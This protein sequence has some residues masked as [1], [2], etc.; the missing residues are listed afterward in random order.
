MTTTNTQEDKSNN[1]SQ[2]ITDLAIIRKDV[3]QISQVFN[4]V[5]HVFE[6]MTE[7]HKTVAVLE[8]MFVSIEKRIVLLEQK[9]IKDAEA[10]QLFK[11]EV[12][13]ELEVRKKEDKEEREKR[14]QELLA[15]IE[16]FNRPVATQMSDQEKRIQSLENWRWY[17][18]GM[19]VIILMVLDKVPFVN[20]FG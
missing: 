4:K 18:I 5:D 3:E 17:L 7:I 1:N 15:S 11:R 6:K 16:K 9:S 12:T 20:L 13:Q 8:T 2:F 10:F 19:G 14:H